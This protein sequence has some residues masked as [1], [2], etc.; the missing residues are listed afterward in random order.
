[1]TTS[2]SFRPFSQIPTTDTTNSCPRATGAGTFC[3]S[4]QDSDPFGNKGTPY[5]FVKIIGVCPIF[6]LIT[7]VNREIIHSPQ[8]NNDKRISR[9]IIICHIHHIYPFPLFPW[10]EGGNIGCLLLRPVVLVL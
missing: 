9:T 4:P 3:T 8:M 1:M 5:L 10:G 7:V 6:V 2:P